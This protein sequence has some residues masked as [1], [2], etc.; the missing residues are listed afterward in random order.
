MTSPPASFPPRRRGFSSLALLSAGAL[1]LSSS[2]A[3]LLAFAGD[4][5][6]AGAQ[7]SRAPEGGVHPVPGTGVPRRAARARPP[8][9]GR[10]LEGVPADGRR[11]VR[12]ERAAVRPELGR[13]RPPAG[14]PHPRGGGGA[15]VVP[16]LWEGSANGVNTGNGKGLTT[17]PLFGW[18]VR[19]GTALDLTLYHDSQSVYSDELGA[20]WTWTYDVYVNDLGG[21]PVLHW[22]DGTAIPYAASGSGGGGG[23]TLDPGGPG[24]GGFQSGFGGPPGGGP[25]G[26]PGGPATYAA[27]SGIHDALV[28]NADGTWT[29]TRKDGTLYTFNAAGFLR[30]V[31]DRNGNA[32]VLTLDSGNYVTRIADPTG[33]YVDVAQDASHRFTSMT[34]HTGRTWAFAYSA[35]GDLASVTPPSLDR[36]TMASD[37]L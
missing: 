14:L 34:D 4:L 30:R 20:G 27:P 25:S 36:G 9:A 5:R 18:T 33:R 19:G 35:S 2:G 23:G 6:E 28:R 16:P 22:G 3:G 7:L 17:L 15:G 13:G 26:D 37:E 31:Q 29:A 24:G 21:D 12:R 8:R 10:P 1:L 11:G 32:I